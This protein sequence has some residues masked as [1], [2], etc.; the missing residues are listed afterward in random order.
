VRLSRRTAVGGAAALGTL[1]VT[2]CTPRGIDARP[3]PAPAARRSPDADPDVT[4]AA[5]VLA[6]E[7][8]MLDRVL[9][10]V[11]QHPGLRTTLAATR[12][13]HTAHVQLLT[14][15]VPHGASP[16]ATPSSTSG[17]RP[18]GARVPAR[19]GV[20][21]AAL[22]RA[23]DRLSLLGRRSA[24]DA[25]SGAFARVLASMAAASAQQSR[26]LADAAGRA[27]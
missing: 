10:T 11:R 18:G 3:G 8:G 26:T 12:T 14:A 7:Q 19:A 16:A 25:R 17:S 1:A 23:E 5:S 24:F 21:L 6:E 13:A 2:G 27:R 15:A 4:L 22:A 20:A 9:A